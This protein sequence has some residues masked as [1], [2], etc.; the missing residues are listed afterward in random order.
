MDPISHIAFAYILAGGNINVW[1]ILGAVV[2]DLDKIF[3]YTR[4]KFRGQESRT[5]LH[6]LSIAAPLIVASILINNALCLGLISHY[7]LD[8]LLGESKPFHPFFDNIVDFNLNLR[9]KIAIGAGLWLTAGL[10][11]M[12]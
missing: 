4:K 8:F 5:I 9:Y 10:F 11:I 2:L 1:L 12:L 6:E 3:T 7:V